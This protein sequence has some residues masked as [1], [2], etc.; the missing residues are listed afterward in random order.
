VLRVE[1]PLQLRADAVGE[2]RRGL[3]FAR[4]AGPQGDHAVGD[5]RR[6]LDDPRGVEVLQKDA[7]RLRVERVRRA[8]LTLEVEQDRRD[9]P[10]GRRDDFLAHA[11]DFHVFGRFHGQGRLAVHEAVQVGLR[12]AVAAGQTDE[13]AA[14]RVDL[15]VALEPGVGE[16]RDLFLGL[17]GLARGTFRLLQ[18]FRA[19]LHAPLLAQRFLEGRQ[20]FLLDAEFLADGEKLLQDLVQQA[21]LDDLARA[22]L[23]LEGEDD[24]LGQLRDHRV[25]ELRALGEHGGH[26]ADDVLPRLALRLKPLGFAWFERIVDEIEPDAALLFRPGVA[27]VGRRLVHVGDEP[28]AVELLQLRQR[29]AECGVLPEQPVVAV[30]DHGPERFGDTARQVDRLQAR[31]LLRLRKGDLGARVRCEDADVFCKA[32]CALA[33]VGVQLG[34]Q[35]NPGVSDGVAIPGPVLR[36]CARLGLEA[37]C[38]EHGFQLILEE[39]L[40]DAC[41]DAPAHGL[42]QHGEHGRRADVAGHDV[43]QLPGV[44][45][46]ACM[47]DHG[48]E[49]EVR[50]HQHG[51]HP[52]R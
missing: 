28:V 33:A 36:L 6:E 45:L 4:S 9:V 48:H 30:L 31:H 15:P 37:R 44:A 25:L 24:G 39:R 10:G 41:H 3:L 14:G 52:A 17:C 46:E 38:L 13:E 20:Q 34:V 22:L 19:D 16:H 26:D 8:G 5:P 49:V 43:S 21:Q 2:C 42:D 51:D 1:L 11:R 18:L 12:N 40:L 23:L 7:F 50:D 32:S 47:V 29:V 35:G 27:A